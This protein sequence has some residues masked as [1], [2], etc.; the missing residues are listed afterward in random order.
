MPQRPHSY[1]P[2]PLHDHIARVPLRGVNRYGSRTEWEPEDWHLHAV[3]AA[4]DE[5]VALREISHKVT[6]WDLKWDLM[7]RHLGMNLHIFPIPSEH[8][9]T[10]EGKR[11][12]VL[13][14][15]RI[16]MNAKAGK[17][18]AITC[19]QGYRRTAAAIYLSHGRMGASHEEALTYSR[20]R[21]EV[22]AFS[23]FEQNQLN[24][25]YEEREKYGAKSKE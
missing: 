24:Q 12:L 21:S 2:K 7:H 11:N 1:D 8:I 3:A 10:E 13:A 22:E 19:N 4:P 5:I 9:F 18:T 23:E 16:V 6:D 14:S 17:K 20:G 25:L 15:E